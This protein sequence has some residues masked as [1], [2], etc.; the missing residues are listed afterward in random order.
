MGRQ[1][2]RFGDQKKEEAMRCKSCGGFLYHEGIDD[3]DRRIYTCHTL[4][5]QVDPENKHLSMY[6][7]GTAFDVTS[8]KQV[9][10]TTFE[11]KWAYYTAIKVE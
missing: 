8:Q 11:G 10:R 9:E 5:T 4:L 2:H 1:R 6:R 3:Y 7:C